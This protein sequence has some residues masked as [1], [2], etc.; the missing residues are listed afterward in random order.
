M[1]WLEEFFPFLREI[2]QGSGAL[3]VAL[4]ALV[5]GILGVIGLA[6]VR[7]RRPGPVER[8]STEADR[9]DGRPAT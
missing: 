5:V 3:E 4:V 9:D 7:R 6:V 2:D 8:A 1:D